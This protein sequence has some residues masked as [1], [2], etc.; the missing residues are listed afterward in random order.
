VSPNGHINSVG[1]GAAPWRTLYRIL[2]EN[3]NSNVAVSYTH[4]RRNDFTFMINCL[5]LFQSS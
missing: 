3:A 5:N 2:P 1:G 4:G